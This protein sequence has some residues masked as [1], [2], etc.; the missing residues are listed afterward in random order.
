MPSYLNTGQL[1]WW[2]LASYTPDALKFGQYF[3]P[4]EAPLLDPRKTH[5]ALAPA[6][7]MRQV[8]K[9]DEDSFCHD[10]SLLHLVSAAAHWSV[11]AERSTLTAEISSSE[12]PRVTKN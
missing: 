9:V 2:I 4:D 8:V 1:A 10:S 11:W 5:L 7:A 12:F 6:E 3:H